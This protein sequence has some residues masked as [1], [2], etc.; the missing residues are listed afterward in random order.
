MWLR[1]SEFLFKFSVSPILLA[2]ALSLHTRSQEEEEEEEVSV[3]YAPSSVLEV[4]SL[5]VYLSA[6]RG[7]KFSE[8]N[9]SPPLP[10]SSFLPSQH[11]H[12][13]CCQLH[14]LPLTLASSSNKWQCYFFWSGRRKMSL[15]ICGKSQAEM[16]WNSDNRTGLS[17]Y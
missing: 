14:F 16:Q 7:R 4:L 8:V 12:R 17:S 2:P 10:S 6:F 1:A 9:L 5:S 13:R 11:H 3:V 15:Q